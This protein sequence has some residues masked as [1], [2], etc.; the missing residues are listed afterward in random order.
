[1]KITINLY[2][3]F[4]QIA[5]EKSIELNLPAGTTVFEAIR[6]ATVKFP[7]LKP[8]WF[9]D[10]WELFPHVHVMLAGDDVTTLPQKW[11]TPLK[12]GANLEVFP[13]VA[14]G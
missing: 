11:D 6:A 7:V 9:N 5:G 4:R 14:G 10:Q 1:M 3:T 8:H 12:E 13:P 2:A